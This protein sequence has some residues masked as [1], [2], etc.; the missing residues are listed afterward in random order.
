MAFMSLKR[1]R[2]SREN[3]N[4]IFARQVLAGNEVSERAA[5]TTKDY[6]T[7]APVR[8]GSEERKQLVAKTDLYQGS[9]MCCRCC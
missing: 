9:E 2:Q 7:E 1:A 6:F 5:E 3:T 8:D 4:I